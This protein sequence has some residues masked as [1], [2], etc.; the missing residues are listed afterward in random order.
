[1]R[2]RTCWG[3]RDRQQGVALAIVVWFIAGMSLLVA[4]LVYQARQD[5]RMSQVHIARAKAVAAG[6]GA[7]NLLLANLVTGRLPKDSAER[8]TSQ[9]FVLGQT[10]VA[11]HLYPSS[12]L[13]NLNAAGESMLESLFRVAASLDKRDAKLLAENVVKWRTSNDGSG[14]RR[15]SRRHFDAIEDLLNVQGVDRTLYDAVRDFVAAGPPGGRAI[16]WSASPGQVLD[17]L[18]DIDKSKLDSVVRRRDSIARSG[19]GPDA[20][21]SVRIERGYRAD[22]FVSYGDKTWL[23]RRWITMEPVSGSNL[24]W[25]VV[26]SEAPRMVDGSVK[27]I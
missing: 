21:S 27:E 19:G 26:R 12:G 6:D 7:I 24:R 10:Q 16:D 1:M 4:G 23:R 11:V 22:A 13:L 8:M 25:R 18:E 20:S 15:G 5:V 14:R 17:V 3:C 2:A 9:Q